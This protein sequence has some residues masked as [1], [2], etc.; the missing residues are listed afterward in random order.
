M[1]RGGERSLWVAG[2][3]ELSLCQGAG[4]GSG[5][6][7]CCH[8]A[9]ISGFFTADQETPGGV[10]QFSVARQLNFKEAFFSGSQSKNPHS[11]QGV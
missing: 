5:K 9:Q 4:F 8:A 10:C 6:P 11:H 7:A 2:R 3:L 1:R